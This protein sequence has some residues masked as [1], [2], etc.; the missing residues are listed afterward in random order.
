MASLTSANTTIPAVQAVPEVHTVPEVQ[1][2][3]TVPEVQVEGGASIWDDGFL[4]SF[5]EN[6]AYDP[7]VNTPFEGYVNISPKQKGEFGEQFVER[8][9]TIMDLSVERA[10][11]STAGHD[12]VI[13]GY[14][15][16][17]KFSVAHRDDLKR[18]LGPDGLNIKPNCFT[19][20]HI[21]VE[22]DWERLLFVGINGANK[23]DW[24]IKWFTKEDFVTE[25][26]S[27]NT[28]FKH[29]QGG[30]KSDNDDYMCA[31]TRAEQLVSKPWVHLFSDW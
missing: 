30:K 31:G 4:R 23:S 9:A 6:N 27:P 25:L 12:R 3:H 21:A 24:V 17:I 20:N 18:G 26:Q 29:Q 19:F 15:T 2:V 28:I 11:T 10:P 22:K 1:E 16:E 8:Y 13:D 5:I 14:R 7:W